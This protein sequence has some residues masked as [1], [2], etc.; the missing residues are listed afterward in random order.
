[1]KV[2][3]S[4]FVAG[5]LALLVFAFLVAGA[6]LLIAVVPVVLAV[7]LA[8][9][10]GRDVRHVVRHGLYDPPGA[11]GGSGPGTDPREPNPHLPS[12]DMIDA[13]WDGFV[14]QFWEY[15]ERESEREVISA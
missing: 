5:L 14:S 1:M 4:G 12:G 10:V 7:G 2:I 3:A 11:D 6:P 9:A 13:D 8:A 15:V